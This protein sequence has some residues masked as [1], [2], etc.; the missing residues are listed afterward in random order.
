MASACPLERRPCPCQCRLSARPPI[1]NPVKD[2]MF[3]SMPFVL[4]ALVLLAVLAG[5][6]ILYF[7]LAVFA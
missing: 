1:Y 4:T 3:R 7:A 2:L 5:A 6:A